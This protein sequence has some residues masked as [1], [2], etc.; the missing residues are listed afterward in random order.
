MRV[1]D[2]MTTNEVRNEPW[3]AWELFAHIE[4]SH[5]CWTERSARLTYDL[6]YSVD[7]GMLFEIH[8]QLIQ[9]QWHIII[10]GQFSWRC[11][12][13]ALCMALLCDIWWTSSWEC[14]QHNFSIY[15]EVERTQLCPFYTHEFAQI[16]CVYT[17]VC[18][19]VCVSVCERERE[20]DIDTFHNRCCPPNRDD[21]IKSSRS[22]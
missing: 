21:W 22:K 19:G 15:R 18:V 7:N 8:R 3:L 17:I 14:E 13:P 5:I 6:I 16:I 1:P 4:H 2:E 11:T 20:H 12:L 10:I 9:R